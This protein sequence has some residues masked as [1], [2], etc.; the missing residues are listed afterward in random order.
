MTG[1]K[2]KKMLIS[3]IDFCQIFKLEFDMNNQLIDINVVN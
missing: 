1:V 3:K 2:D